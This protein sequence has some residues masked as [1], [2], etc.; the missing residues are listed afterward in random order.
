MAREQRLEKRYGTKTVKQVRRGVHKALRNYAKWK[1]GERVP[2]RIIGY[3]IILEEKNAVNIYV[4]NISIASKLNNL[5]RK[6][7]DAEETA[8]ALF[9]EGKTEKQ[10]TRNQKLKTL[11]INSADINEWI[12]GSIRRDGLVSS[13]LRIVL[14]QDKLCPICLHAHRHSTQGFMPKLT[15]RPCLCNP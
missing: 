2:Q 11:S 13:M 7:A 1:R 12:N 10:L 6:L 14:K 5:D 15:C 3:L 8:V 4:D 9:L